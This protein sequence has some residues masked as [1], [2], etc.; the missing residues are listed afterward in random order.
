M[1]ADTA[2]VTNVR[3]ISASGAKWQC[4]KHN[5]ET[6]YKEILHG[7]SKAGTRLR[8]GIVI[9]QSFQKRYGDTLH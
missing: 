9:L 3:I 4:I 2:R 5:C 7:R 1:F 6:G 8:C